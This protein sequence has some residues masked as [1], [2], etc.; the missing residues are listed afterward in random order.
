ME[1]FIRGLESLGQDQTTYGG[2]LVPII[3]DKLPGEVREHSAREHGDK[4]WILRKLRCAI[5]REIHIA[6]KQD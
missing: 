4:N 3:L 2:L 6:T 5:F 1:T